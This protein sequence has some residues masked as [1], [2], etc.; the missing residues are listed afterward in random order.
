M[1]GGH[2]VI[3]AA[4]GLAGD[5]GDLGH[6]ALG[7]GVEQLGA[8]LDDAAVFLRSAGHEAGHVH[9]GDDRDVERITKAHKARGL[10]ARLD[11]QATGQHQ[12]LIG[13]DAH[14][15]A[16]HAGKTDDDVLG[17]LGLQLEEVPVVHR[18][19]DQLLHVV[20]FVR[21]V[22]HQ[23]V[24]AQV[25]A[26]GRV[27]AGAHRGFFAVVERQVVVQAAQ[28]HQRLHVVL[29]RHV[30]HATLGGVG[31]GTAQFFGRDFFVRHGLDHFGAGHEHVR[32]VLHHED[33]VRHGG[34]VHGATGAGAHDHADLRDHAGR[35]HILLEH[36]GIATQG[37][38]ALLDARA[39]RVVQADHRRTDLHGLVHD[40]ADLLGV[41]LGQ[42]AAEHCEVL[43]EDEYQAAVD[44]AVA[45]DHAVARH[46]VVLHAKVR[47]AVLHEHVPFFK[48]AVV[49]QQLNALA[50][51]ELALFVLG[52]D[53]LLAPAQAGKFAL[54]LQLVQDVLHGR[55]SV[56]CCL[57]GMNLLFIQ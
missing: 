18:L 48:G 15:L 30:G 54:F 33:E 50:G 17:V 21:V 23:R 53:A 32:A 25:H 55:P 46:L 3:R 5:D 7:I 6:G 44:H 19:E 4:V 39:A 35:Q 11:V 9:K 14:H 37:S 1:L 12:R 42:R 10:D 36:V 13:H 47:A 41:G 26:V 2:H 34:R 57:V 22:G 29:K 24:Q 45:G 49:Q 16:F 56:K 51:G 20:R 28:H 8:V 31:D 27:V 52:V 38:H 43:T 40:L